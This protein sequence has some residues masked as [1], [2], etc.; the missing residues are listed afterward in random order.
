M[1]KP[2][3]IDHPVHDL[4]QRRWSPVGFSPES[5]PAE[6]VRSLLEAAR[7]APS[8]FNEQPWAFLVADRNDPVAHELMVSCLVPGNQTWAREAPVLMIALART[9]LA[10]NDKPNRHALYDVGQAVAVMT[11]QA[12]AEGLFAHQ[13][14]GIDVERIREAYALPEDVEPVAGSALGRPG[15]LEALPVDLRRRDEGPRRRKPQAEWVFAGAWGEPAA[16]DGEE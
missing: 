4:I 9:R 10:R 5:L 11:V 3:P 14:G 8:A 15:D 16:T 2:A 6:S 7:W 12:T 1:E 13:M